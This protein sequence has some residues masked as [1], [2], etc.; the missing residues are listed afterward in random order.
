[1]A[2]TLTLSKCTEVIECPGGYSDSPVMVVVGWLPVLAVIVASQCLK[3]YLVDM[4]LLFAALQRPRSVLLS[5]PLF[6]GWILCKHIR[7][8]CYCRQ[9]MFSVSGWSIREAQFPPDLL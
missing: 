6:H 9:V 7:T 8:Y 3:K 5:L 2:K 4:I 1:V